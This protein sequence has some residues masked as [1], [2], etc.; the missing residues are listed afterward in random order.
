MKIGEHD[1]RGVGDRADGEVD[2]G[3]EDDEGQADG[4]DRGHRHLLK[5]VLEIAERGEGRAR[6]AEEGD[7]RDQGYEGGDVAELIAQEIADAKG[8]CVSDL[9]ALHIHLKT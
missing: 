2:F 4:D 9:G 6:D 3:G 5:D 7:E 1:R 8:A